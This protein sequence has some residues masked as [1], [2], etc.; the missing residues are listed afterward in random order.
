M[1]PLRPTSHPPPP[2]TTHPLFCSFRNTKWVLVRSLLTVLRVIPISLIRTG[3]GATTRGKYLVSS[4]PNITNFIMLYCRR[5]IILNAW[6]AL[7]LI[8]SSTNGFDGSMMNGLQALPQWQSAFNHPGSSM[9]GLLNAI[10]NIG[11]LVALPFAPY[12]S[13]GIGRRPSVLLGAGIMVCPSPITRSPV[14][15]YSIIVIG[16]RH[17]P[18]DRFPECWHVYW[19]SFSHRFRSHLR[20]EWRGNADYRI[21]LSFLPRPSNFPL[22]L[23]LVLRCHRCRLEYLRYLQDQ[24]FLVLEDPIRSS[25]SSI[26][27]PTWS[28]LVWARISSLVGEQG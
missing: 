26:C 3:L 2:P 17:C 1:V 7:L 25:G 10:Q 28:P 5:L 11:A 21:G 14:T 6:I 20:F 4:S 13:D 24:L 15:H 16:G 8:T 12:L 23:P 18:P 22:Q 9:L 27:S 19:R